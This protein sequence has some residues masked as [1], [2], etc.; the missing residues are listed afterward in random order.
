M[1]NFLN[2]L[3]ISVGFSF[4][5]LERYAL[6]T[7][8]MIDLLLLILSL[9]SLLISEKRF[10]ILGI[11]KLFMRREL[12]QMI[13]GLTGLYFT[14]GLASNP[15]VHH[16]IWLL[17]PSTKGL[18]CPCQRS[19]WFLLNYQFIRNLNYAGHKYKTIL[20]ITSIV[21]LSV[22]SFMRN[23]RD[24]LALSRKMPQNRSVLQLYH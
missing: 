17:K 20:P 19:C 3:S 7:R 4:R 1:V 13:K 6:N 9:V 2:V 5:L 12:Y 21:K 14:N 22:R 24:Q 15:K 16:F 10:S 23:N 8:S 11:R 18:L